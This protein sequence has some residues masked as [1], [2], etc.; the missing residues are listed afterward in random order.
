MPVIVELGYCVC[1]SCRN[2]CFCKGFCQ[3]FWSCCIKSKQRHC[4]QLTK[5]I[6]KRRV[7]R[8]AAELDLADMSLNGECKEKVLN[9]HSFLCGLQEGSEQSRKK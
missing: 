7:L 9:D 4:I 2:I 8:C 3:R 5:G 6:I 1:L